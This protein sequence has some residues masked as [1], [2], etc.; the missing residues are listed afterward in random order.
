MC[1]SVYVSIGCMCVCVCPVSW[2]LI[3]KTHFSSYGH[4]TPLEHYSE[5]GIHIAILMCCPSLGLLLVSVRCDV[6]PGPE[7]IE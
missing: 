3:L 5:E 7:L 6:L 1:P 4:F 2:P